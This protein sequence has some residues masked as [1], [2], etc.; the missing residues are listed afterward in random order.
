MSPVGLGVDGMAIWLCLCWVLALAVWLWLMVRQLNDEDLKKCFIL[1]FD[2]LA[3][4]MSSTMND[5]KLLQ[6]Y[7]FSS[8]LPGYGHTALG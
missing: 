3:Y 2:R 8:H 7:V 1:D 4:K 6:W 5:D